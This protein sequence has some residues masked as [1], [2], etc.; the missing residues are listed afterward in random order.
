M[1]STFTDIKTLLEEAERLGQAKRWPEAVDV[2]ERARVL[3]PNDTAVLDKLG[4]YLSRSKRYDDAIRVY[5][6]L[7][8]KQPGWAKW[9]YTV[10]YQF[11]EQGKWKEAIEWFDRAL[12]LRPDYLVVLYRAG[13]AYTQVGDLDRATQLFEK[14]VSEWRNLNAEQQAREGKHYSDACFQLGK[15]L[16]AKG[17]TLRAERYLQDAVKHG[18]AEPHKHYN[19]GKALLKNGKAKEA[20]EQFARSRQ[21]QPGKDYLDVFIARAYVAESDLHS[22]EAALNRISPKG[23]KAYVWREL[24]RVQLL[25]GQVAEAVESLKKAVILNSVNHNTYYLL[26]QAYEATGTYDGARSAWQAYETAISLRK[27]CYDLDFADARE[28]LNNLEAQYPDM[29]QNLTRTNAEVIEESQPTMAHEKGRIK[30]YNEPRGFGFLSWG[31]NR[32]L[33]FHISDVDK[34][35]LIRVGARVAFEVIDTSKGPRAT[36]IALL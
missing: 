21:L 11:Y 28:R 18:P 1:V 22:A 5:S 23:R 19:L 30:S 33:F 13:Y 31:D 9:P 17:Q 24:G 3:A 8:D 32:D 7:S 35:E 20:L 12:K 29:E 2:C 16:L 34:P 26:A 15:L 25:K 6:E 14:C 4:W 10:G 27:K 36:R